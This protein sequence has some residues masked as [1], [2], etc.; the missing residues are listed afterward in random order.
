[1]RRSTFVKKS[2]YKILL[3]LASFAEAVCVG[4]VGTR[5]SA[6]FKNCP[7]VDR[8][9]LLCDVRMSCR[10]LDNNRLHLAKGAIL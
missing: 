5:N 7:N 6:W 2:L 8:T 3:M 4:G 9:L 1:M 10:I